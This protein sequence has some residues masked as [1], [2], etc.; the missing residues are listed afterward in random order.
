MFELGKISL[1][2]KKCLIIKK[3]MT[4]N[5]SDFLLEIFNP[6]PWVRIRV[7]PSIDRQNFGMLGSGQS[8]LL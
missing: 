1:T 5:N 8:Y 4:P 3:F 7:L 6:I 2:I